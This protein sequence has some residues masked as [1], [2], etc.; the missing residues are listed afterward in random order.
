VLLNTGKIGESNVKELNVV[1]LDELQHLGGIFE[2]G[3]DSK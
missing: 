1:V 2:H 3:G